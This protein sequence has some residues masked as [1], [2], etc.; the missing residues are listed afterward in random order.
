LLIKGGRDYVK[1]SDSSVGIALG[2]ALY[3][4]GFESRQGLGIYL[5]TAAS[6]TAL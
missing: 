4:P 6:R 5:Y 3:D 1:S 2:Y